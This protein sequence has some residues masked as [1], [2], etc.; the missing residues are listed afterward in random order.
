M[1]NT[2]KSYTKDFSMFSKLCSF[3]EYLIKRLGLHINQF[4]FASVTGNFIKK[5]DSDTGVFLW[6]CEISKN[7]FFTE[8]LQT[9]ASVER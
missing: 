4:C 1:L 2:L 8:H 7:N 9:T 3:F 5:R 6:F